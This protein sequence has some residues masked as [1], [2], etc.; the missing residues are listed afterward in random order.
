[1]GRCIPGF[2]TNHI[3]GLPQQPAQLSRKNSKRKDV[4]VRS[5][6]QQLTAAGLAFNEIP[7]GMD[8]VHRRP[9]VRDML[10]GLVQK[11]VIGS[12]D[13][14]GAD[15]VGRGEFLASDGMWVSAEC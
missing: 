5:W 2:N 13:M 4:A 6:V 1:M 9:T 10:T 12:I 7:G 11:T 8:A 15:C 3:I 14:K